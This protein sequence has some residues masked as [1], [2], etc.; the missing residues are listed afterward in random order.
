L[1]K[2]LVDTNKVAATAAVSA[3]FMVGIVS[4]KERCS[5]LSLRGR[6]ASNNTCFSN[7]S[8]QVH[9]NRKNE[10]WLVTCCLLVVCIIS[11]RK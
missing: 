6:Q 2:A 4:Y 5:W 1:E 7:C 9:L 8:T 3:I 11:L 10:I